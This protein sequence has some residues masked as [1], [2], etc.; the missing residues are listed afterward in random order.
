MKTMA[1][2]SR[3]VEAGGDPTALRVVKLRREAPI[4]SRRRMEITRMFTS[5]WTVAKSIS[6][7]TAFGS[8]AGFTLS[9]G[10]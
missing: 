9:T 6:T 2:S 4:K 10:R 3:K 8:T 7:L 1:R 5:A